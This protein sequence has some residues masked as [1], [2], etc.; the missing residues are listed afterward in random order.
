MRSVPAP[1]LR[2]FVVALIGTSLAAAHVA[3]A[4][5]APAQGKSERLAENCYVELQ[6]IITADGKSLTKRVVESD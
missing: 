3:F 1:L 5:A 4:A 2:G 6:T